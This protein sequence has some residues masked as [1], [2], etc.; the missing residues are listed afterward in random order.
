[1]R[2][3]LAPLL[4]AAGL[5]LAP[6]QAVHAVTTLSQPMVTSNARTVQTVTQSLTF[7]PTLFGGGAT[8]QTLNLAKFTNTAIRTLTGV[9]ISWVTAFGGDI[10][11]TSGSGNTR[12]L[13]TTASYDSRLTSAGNLFGF[14]NAVSGTSPD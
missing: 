8:T 9:T 3:A 1:M 5:A 6:L 11:A 4:L 2:P 14:T 13:R 10:T 12:T 7:S